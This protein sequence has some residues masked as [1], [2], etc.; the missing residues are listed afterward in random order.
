MATRLD[1]SYDQAVHKVR[2]Q[3]NG[4]AQ[5]YWK[6]LGSW[7]DED[8]DKLVKV[9]VPRI[10]AGQQRIADLTDAYIR[11]LALAE[12]GEIKSGLPQAA[13]TLALRGVPAAEVYHRPFASAYTELARGKSVSSAVAAGADR[14]SSL[15]LSGLQLAKTH[16]ARDTMSRTRYESFQRTL[17]G[18]ENCALCVVASTQRYTRGDLLPIHPGCD[19]GVK[20]FYT[21][22]DKQVIDRPLLDETYTEIATRLDHVSVGLDARDLGLGKTDARGRPLSDFTD[23]LITNQH[24]ELGPLLAWRDHKFTSA[25]DIYALTH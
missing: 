1:R 23:L 16:A 21:E 7:R 19:C 10:E 15:V 22:F 6:G 2:V 18:R 24:G 12:F 11:R 13:S 5:R 17:T 8:F 9:L 4:F 25:D 20:P 3:L 14:L